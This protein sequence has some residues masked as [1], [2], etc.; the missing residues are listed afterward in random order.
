MCGIREQSPRPEPEAGRPL[1][2]G[3]GQTVDLT[4]PR[5]G[6]SAPS[7]RGGPLRNPRASSWVAR[8]TPHRFRLAED[9]RGTRPLLPLPQER[10]KIAAIRANP[11]LRAFACRSGRM[12]KLLV[13]SCKGLQGRGRSRAA[14]LLPPGA[15]SDRSAKVSRGRRSGAVFAD[16]AGFGKGLPGKGL[17][18]GWALRGWGRLERVLRSGN[19]GANRR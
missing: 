11:R 14:P 3:P 1:D 16:E 17:R 4:H 5:R 6:R 19:A 13:I 12:R 18:S 8:K 15:R 7:A 10:V 9:G 2:P